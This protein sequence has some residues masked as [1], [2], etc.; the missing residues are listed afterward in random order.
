MVSLM[1]R[2]TKLRFDPSRRWLVCQ[3]TGVLGLLPL[4]T[5]QAFPTDPARIFARDQSPI[6]GKIEVETSVWQGGS[7]HE[8]DSGTRIYLERRTVTTGGEGHFDFWLDEAN[9]IEGDLR[10]KKVGLNLQLH[11]QLKYRPPGKEPIQRRIGLAAIDNAY[12]A[13]PTGTARTPGTN[14]H[15]QGS[16]SKSYDP[17]FSEF[18]PEY[19]RRGMAILYPDGR[20][21]TEDGSYRETSGTTTSGVQEFLDYCTNHHV[22]GYIVG[23]SIP[24]RQQVIYRIWTPLRMHPAQG[25]RIDTGAITLQ[26]MPD[27]GD[28]PGLT[29]DSCMMND[30]RIRGLLHYRGSGYALAI[31]PEN[32]LPLDR[33]VGNTIVDSAFF[34]T[35]I[36]CSDA[37][38]AVRFEGSINFC[39]FDFN[40]INHGELG[41]HVAPDGSFSNCR[42]TCKHVHGQTENSILDEGSA[43]N[44]WEVNLN[45]DA[46]DPLGIVTNGQDNIWFSN[47][48]SRNKPGLTLNPNARGN[49]FFLMGLNGGY[50]NQAVEPTNRFYAS[51]STVANKLK[52]GFGVETPSIPASGEL[53]INRNPFPVIVMIKAGGSVSRWELN[54]TYGG[55][56][57]FAGSLQAGQNIYLSPGEGL[58]IHY[59]GAPPEWRWRAVQ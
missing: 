1:Q 50:D 13:W 5:S 29:I 54:D 28:Q 59:S 18:S 42:I 23:G 12:V 21:Q 6:A 3:L 17:K 34:V 14:E 40:E 52:L 22:D 31:K 44:V 49:Q 57:E 24:R 35:A 58:R 56:D 20:L 26:F 27:L 43:K 15:L 47:I 25:I 11:L 16:Y 9:A 19:V 30:I 45:C 55:S 41:I 48:N 4:A 39:R 33:F 36:A 32:P 2:I 7:P 37:R 51:P 46:K 10:G 38:G 53:M 8:V